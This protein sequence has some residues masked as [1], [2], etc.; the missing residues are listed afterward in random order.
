V[1]LVELSRL[2]TRRKYPRDKMNETEKQNSKNK[3]TRD[4]YKH[5]RDLYKA[6]NA[7]KKAY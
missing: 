1:K 2:R 5:T 4:L 7:F 6:I 3:H